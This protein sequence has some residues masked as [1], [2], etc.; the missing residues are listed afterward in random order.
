MKKIIVAI[1]G[2]CLFSASALAMEETFSGLSYTNPPTSFHT[3]RGADITTLDP[4]IT[5]IQFNASAGTLSFEYHV[6]GTSQNSFDLWLSTPQGTSFSTGSYLNADLNIFQQP[7]RSGMLFA[8][9]GMAPGNGG[10]E[11]NIREMTWSGNTLTSAAIDFGERSTDT[12]PNDLLYG[13]FRYNSTIPFS[14]LVPEP[15]IFA[16]AGLGAAAFLLIRRKH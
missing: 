13:S 5:D 9:E 6:P 1:Y 4:G 11:F 3:A 16:L 12:N 7:G 8:Y 14:P 2:S 15:S 10:G